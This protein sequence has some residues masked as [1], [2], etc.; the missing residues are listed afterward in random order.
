[1]A[2]DRNA[3]SGLDA[4]ERVTSRV[5]PEMLDALRLA[6]GHY[7][8]LY[9]DASSEGAHVGAARNLYEIWTAL[10]GLYRLLSMTGAGEV[11]LHG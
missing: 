4:T 7:F 5:T 9:D 2:A 1:M 10:D 3:A 11:V 6:K 8:D